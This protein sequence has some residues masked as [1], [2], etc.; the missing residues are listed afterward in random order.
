MILV[1]HLKRTPM[2]ACDPKRPF[3]LTVNALVGAG[4]LAYWHPAMI[5]RK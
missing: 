5:A 4:F 3:S 1:T 2:D